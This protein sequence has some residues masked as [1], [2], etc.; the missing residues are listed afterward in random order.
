MERKVGVTHP[1][2]PVRTSPPNQKGECARF[3]DYVGACIAYRRDQRH[4]LILPRPL[5][6]AVRRTCARCSSN[7]HRRRCALRSAGRTWRGRSRPLRP[8]GAD[9]PAELL[10]DIPTELSR[11]VLTAT[12][13]QSS[14]PRRRRC[15]A[16]TPHARGTHS[17]CH[18]S[19]VAICAPSGALQTSLVALAQLGVQ[20]RMGR[21]CVRDVY[22]LRRAYAR[23]SV[24][25]CPVSRCAPHDVPG[26]MRAELGSTLDPGQC[27]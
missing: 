13:P 16:P 7:L 25:L 8:S 22:G 15:H 14:S 9:I 23:T 6:Q 21:A 4:E 17:V 12:L 3:Y 11:S 20:M 18:P 19:Q 5:A 10:S 24:R 26:A 2:A 27:S 1:A